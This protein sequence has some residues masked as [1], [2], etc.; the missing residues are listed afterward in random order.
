MEMEHITF[1]ELMADEFE[2]LL[3]E[4]KD[5]ERCLE[6]L[7]TAAEPCGEHVSIITGDIKGIDG[8]VV[9]QKIDKVF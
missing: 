2:R 6:Q 8:V 1:K 5:K 7:K 9:M 3:A 4:R